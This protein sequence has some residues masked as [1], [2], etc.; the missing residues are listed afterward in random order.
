MLGAFDLRAALPGMR[1]PTAI[2]VGEDDYA[3]PVSMARD[4]HNAIPG[5]TLQIIPGLRHLTFVE[6]PDSVAHAMSELMNRVSG[7]RGQGEG[8]RAVSGV[9]L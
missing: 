2:V 7:G 6:R 3:T 8:G 5:S 4:L 1:M 9:S